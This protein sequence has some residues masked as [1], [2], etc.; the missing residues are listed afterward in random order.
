MAM[1]RYR[2][3]NNKVGIVRCRYGQPDPKFKKVTPL[4]RVGL[5]ARTLLPNRTYWLT[6]GQYSVEFID[7][8]SVP[9]ECIGVVTALE[10]ANRPRHRMVGKHVECDNFQDGEQFLLSDGEQ[11]PQIATLTGGQT[12]YI[13]TR[14]F[15]VEIVPRTYVPPGTVGLVTARAGRVPSHGSRFGKHVECDNFQDGLA[16]LN[17]GGEQGRQLAILTGGAYYDINPWLFSVT[18]VDNV[19]ND[20]QGLTVAHLQDVHVPLEETGVVVTLEGAEPEQSD[21]KTVGPRVPGHQNFRLPWVFLANG[22][23]RGVQGETINGG[24]VLALNPWFVRVVTI[25]TR[26]LILE[27]DEKSSAEADNYDA[28]L[29]QI[30]VIIQG[31]DV[32]VE[33]TQTLSIPESSAPL[34]VSEFGYSETSALGGLV[35]DRKPIQRFVEK[36]LGA[37]VQSFFNQMA[38]ESSAPEFLHRISERRIDLDHQIR[39]DL[40]EW[41]V[42]TK[43]IALRSFK[44]ENSQLNETLRKVAVGEIEGDSLEQELENAKIKDKIDEIEVRAKRRRAALE[45]EAMID[46]IGPNNTMVIQLVRETAKMSVPNY[47]GGGN[48]TELIHQLPLGKLQYILDQLRPADQVENTSPPA[49]LQRGPESV[50]Q[51]NLDVLRALTSIDMDDLSASE[52]REQNVPQPGNTGDERPGSPAAAPSQKRSSRVRGIMR[53]SGPESGS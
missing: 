52:V 48:V 26:A 43:P 32:H 35:N 16:F 1:G 14:L 24:S 42:K 21:K 45:L 20:T 13:N 49:E 38:A 50:T 27:W 44:A 9:P 23:T 33:M 29:D 36:V 28:K 51:S 5:Q 41:G 6:P 31:C 19:K 8:I 7:P 22:G 46:A 30:T 10:G 3:P 11:G 53:P 47:I 25:P 2:V 37:T 4:D 39:A 15:Q 12:Y 34:L 17:A 18:T 40:S